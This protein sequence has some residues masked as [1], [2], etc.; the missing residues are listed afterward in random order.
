MVGTPKHNKLDQEF[1]LELWR[2]C[3][4]KQNIKIIQHDLPK[5]LQTCYLGTLG[6]SEYTRSNE[7]N[8]LR[9]LMRFY[10]R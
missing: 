4:Y 7:W 1:Y 9:P 6:M 8:Q 10:P 2:R 5:I 3:I